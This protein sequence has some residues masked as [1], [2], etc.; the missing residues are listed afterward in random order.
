MHVAAKVRYDE[1]DGKSLKKCKAF[2]VLDPKAGQN[3]CKYLQA[4]QCHVLHSVVLHSVMYCTV[5]CT[6]PLVMMQNVE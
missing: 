1:V 5:S 3:L 4:A 2:R 6:L